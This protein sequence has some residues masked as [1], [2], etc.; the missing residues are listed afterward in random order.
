MCAASFRPFAKYGGGV[1]AFGEGIKPSCQRPR[2]RPPCRGGPAAREID[3]QCVGTIAPEG[4]KLMVGGIGQDL[5]EVQ[6]DGIPATAGL[7]P[8]EIGEVGGA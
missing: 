5:V 7:D 8:L 6:R 1:D 3:V 2:Y 4:D